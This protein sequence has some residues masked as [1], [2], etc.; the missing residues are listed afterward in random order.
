MDGNRARRLKNGSPLG[1]IIDEGGDT[2]TMG[3]YS[4][5]LAYAWHLPLPWMDLLY[6][7]FNFIFFAMEM[8]YTITGDLI[9]S[10]GE[11]GPV[12]LELLFSASLMLMG[13]Y[14]NEVMF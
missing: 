9:M 12:E 13:I 11:L 2:V 8:K 3:H 10:V 4:V 7:A 6:F 1:R 5:L 14:G